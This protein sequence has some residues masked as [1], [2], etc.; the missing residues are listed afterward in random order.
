MP[1]LLR[2][3]ATGPRSLCCAGALLV[4]GW[5]QADAGTE[6]DTEKTLPACL[7]R[8]H[9]PA[10]VSTRVHFLIIHGRNTAYLIQLLVVRST[11]YTALVRVHPSGARIPEHYHRTARVID[12]FRWLSDG[13]LLYRGTT[14][15]LSHMPCGNLPLHINLAPL[16]LGRQIEKTIDRYSV[17]R[18]Y[19]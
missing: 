11:R 9:C 6:F 19:I 18:E 17:D 15:S 16:K 1:A 8:L 2:A 3:R 10:R 4:L 13:G 14:R 12:G 7:T 5:R